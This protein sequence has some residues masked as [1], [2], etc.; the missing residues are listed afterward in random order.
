MLKRFFL[1][2]IIITIIILNLNISIILAADVDLLSPSIMLI[3]KSSTEVRNG[4]TIIFNVT[5]SDNVAISNITLS[6]KDIILNG[7]SADIA[8]SESVNKRIITLSNI[9]GEV[10]SNKYISIKSGTAIDSSGNK[11]KGIERSIY[12]RIVNDVDNKNPEINLSN[13]SKNVVYEGEDLEYVIRYSDNISIKKINLIEK[14]ITLNGFL[15]DV[16]IKNG[17]TENERIIKLMNIRGDI[18]N[19]NSITI[20]S[21]TAVDYVGNKAYGISMSEKFSIADRISTSTGTDIELPLDDKLSNISGNYENFV[22]NM[23]VDFLIKEDIKEFQ[24]FTTVKRDNVS[25]IVENSFATDGSQATYK[26]QYYNNKDENIEDAKITLNIPKG[27]ELI[28]ASANGKIIHQTSNLT[29]IQW[30]LQDIYSKEG[31]ILEAK[32]KYKNNLS[33]FSKACTEFFSKVNFTSDKMTMSKYIRQVYIN[34]DKKIKNKEYVKIYLLDY[35]VS[36][37]K[38]ITR[39]DFARMILDSN[40]IN[41]SK[42]AD[43]YKIYKDYESIKVNE[44]RAI[45]T[46]TEIN[47]YKPDSEGNIEPNKIITKGEMYSYVTKILEYKYKNIIKKEK[48][49]FYKEV[50]KNNK[51]LDDIILLNQLNIVSL[52]DSIEK[53]ASLKDVLCLINSINYKSTIENSKKIYFFIN[54]KFSNK[55]RYHALYGMK[56]F[57]YYYTKNLKIKIK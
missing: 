55:D 52:N 19:N 37:D 32:V 53:N 36:P 39:A 47:I 15:A 8:I 56:N 4:D 35:L 21:G 44:R 49:I 54:K 50:I 18:S 1:S 5:Y 16:Q 3:Y 41:Y 30:N 11:A 34:A 38:H 28:N 10:G 27:V 22:W 46:F 12:F 31:T 45:S 2:C 42:N 43:K 48:S 9:N 20:S 23:P 17:N 7:F 29:I 24:M 40:I 57:K 26:I 14:D 51:Y 33:K 6:K 13:P 25:E